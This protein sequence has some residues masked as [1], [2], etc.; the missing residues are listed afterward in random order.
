MKKMK[1]E[2]YAQNQSNQRCFLSLNSLTGNKLQ[3]FSTG[4]IKT[5]NTRHI[6]QRKN[7]ATPIPSASSN[8][9]LSI[10]LI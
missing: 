10:I 7:A 2:S 6:E 9:I 5:E 8:Y 3:L 4:R 1:Q